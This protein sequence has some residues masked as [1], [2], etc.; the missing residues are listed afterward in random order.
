[1]YLGRNH[2]AKPIVVE[3]S[4]SE[5][6][7]FEILNFVAGG[8]A[9]SGDTADV[10]I[11]GPTGVTGA[12]GANGSNGSNGANGATGPTG[13]GFSTLSAF[14][15]SSINALPT[16]SSSLVINTGVTIR[17]WQVT[18]GGENMTGPNASDELYITGASAFGTNVTVNYSTND[19]NAVN[20]TTVLIGAVAAG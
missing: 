4:G 9:D 20:D 18:F 17:M 3:N 7:E 10:A 1:M 12:T 15:G 19:F 5:L 16:R 6:G 11:V 14:S 13:P 8:V 2:R